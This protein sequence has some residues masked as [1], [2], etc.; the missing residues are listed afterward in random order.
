MTC[1][2]CVYEVEFRDTDHPVAGKN[3]LILLPSWLISFTNKYLHPC[4]CAKHL[5]ESLPNLPGCLE[6]VKLLS[7]KN[8]NF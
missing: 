5:L 1:R 4:R 8:T 6:H 7:Q 2:P 3:T